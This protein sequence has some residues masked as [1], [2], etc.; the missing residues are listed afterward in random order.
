MNFVV[1]CCFEGVV[2]FVRVDFAGVVGFVRTDFAGVVG[3][4]GVVDFVDIDYIGVSVE[5]VDFA[6]F[7]NN[8]HMFSTL[9][10]TSKT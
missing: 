4:V 10:A 8:L 7:S 2:D 5:Y 9:E 1:V 6:D 3:F